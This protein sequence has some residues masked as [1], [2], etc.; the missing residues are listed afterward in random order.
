MAEDTPEWFN[1]RENPLSRIFKELERMMT[2]NIP[3]DMT[4]E[5]ELPDGSKFREYKSFTYGFSMR[6]GPDGKIEIQEFGNTR[7]PRSPE[8]HHP[9]KP[10]PRTKDALS[11][12][13]RFSD[14]FTKGGEVKAII[15]IPGIQES[16]IALQC[17]GRSLTILVNNEKRDEIELPVE[18]EPEN[19]K[20]TYRN[21]ILEVTLKRATESQNRESKIK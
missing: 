5:D 10:F 18:V 2:T 4:M 13:D 21:S 17:S 14:V 16:E 8:P 19:Y 12:K 6:I 11:K 3:E 9:F 15:E 20:L 1:N 7:P